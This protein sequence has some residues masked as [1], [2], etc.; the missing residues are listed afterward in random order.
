MFVLE[1]FDREGTK[2]N[3]GDYVAVSNS[4]RFTF[5]AEI[6]YL[7]DEGI[8]TPFHTFSFS[9]VVKVD[10]I[11]DNAIRSTEER[12]NIYYVPEEEKDND[13]KRFKEFLL[14]WR[15]CEHHLRTTSW[16]IRLQQQQLELF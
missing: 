4:E 15:K 8:I 3:I 5:Y 1:L 6:K 11:P 14:S 7:I 13:G 10:K 2:L 9:S 12:Y 16:R